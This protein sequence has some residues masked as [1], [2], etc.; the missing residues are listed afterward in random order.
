M[1][2]YV[3]FMEASAMKT[4]AESV[5]LLDWW[6]ENNGWEGY[7]PYDVKGS[8]I[9]LNM[10]KNAFT[11]YV[12][13]T[14]ADFFPSQ[15]RTLL[16]TSKTINSKAMGLFASGYLNLY[17]KSGDRQYLEKAEYC[18]DW[19]EKNSC[20]GY[21]GYCW[22]YPFDWQSKV[23]I[24]K[25]TPSSVVTT[26]VAKAFLDMYELTKDDNCLQ[27]A[28]SSCEFIVND[29]NIDILDER[30]VCFSY[31]PVD[32]FHVHNANLF[33]A[34]LLCKVGSILDLNDYMDLSSKA[35]EYT[36]G[37]QNSDGSWYY[38]GPPDKLLYHIDNYHTGFVLRSLYEI[39]K[40][41][42]D[43]KI[44]KA[45]DKGYKYYVDN[46]FHNGT[47]PKLTNNKLYPIDIHSCSEAIICLSSLSNEYPHSKK[48]IADVSTWILDNMQDEKGYFY[49]RKYQNRTVKIPY[50]RWGQA[51]MLNA[52]S[53]LLS[54]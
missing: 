52:L 41:T 50:M 28:Q 38:W 29:L 1:Q 12:S 37:E 11:R 18:L 30:R 14:F 27:I 26:I 43:M 48:M 45:L 4:I 17:S 46:L 51:W 24:P 16:R 49:Y 9:F 39:Y 53:C 10:E 33:S 13:H 3:Q 8:I 23:F 19:L 25:N 47:V 34:S 22:G 5:K 6:V 35:V 54:I 42:G 36:L 31:T 2:N 44:K 15:L 40:T 21:S 7:D 32:N 20:T